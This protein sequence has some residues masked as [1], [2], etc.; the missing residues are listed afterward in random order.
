MGLM[1]TEKRSLDCGW[2]TRKEI[3]D[4]R[5]STACWLVFQYINPLCYMHVPLPDRLQTRGLMYRKV[6]HHHHH[7]ILST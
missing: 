5:G 1:T 2:L 6:H 3:V 7:I 4:R